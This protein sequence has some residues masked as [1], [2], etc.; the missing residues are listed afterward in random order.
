MSSAPAQ[1][2]AEPRTSVDAVPALELAGITKRY[3]AATVVDNLSLRVD[4]GEFLALVGPS[5]CGKT[6]SLR[7]VAGLVVPD[8]GR[9]LIEGRDVTYA[10]SH[11]RDAIMVFQS[12]ALF[13][14]K[15]VAE[16]VA[17]GLR[18]RKV[19]KEERRRRVAE[20]LALV[21]LPDVGGR[22]PRQ[23]SGGQQQRIALARALVL[24]PTLLLLDEPLSNLDAGLRDQ[25]RIELRRLHQELG[26]TTVL[27]THDQDEALSIASRVAVMNGGRIE[28][29]ARPR[30]LYERPA[31][32]FVAGFVG[33]TNLFAAHVR[34]TGPALRLETPW[35]LQLAA[36]AHDGLSAGDEVRAMIRPEALTLAPADAPVADGVGAARGVLLDVT[37]S[38][39][40]SLYLVRLD[41]GDQLLKVTAPNVEG[42][43]ALPLTPGAPVVASWHP[44]AVRVLAA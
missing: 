41:G 26:T 22:F 25:M 28:Q 31:T 4:Q 32:A 14:H 42:G 39:A 10:P 40:W 27:V 33:R 6:T 7:M 15:S 2:P 11:K 43:D 5:G 44:S 20:A 16:N 9:I 18:R 38:G 8:A 21:G 13:P 34:E 35:G 17:Y 37:Y 3:R 12:Y 19:G 29:L 1:A 36:A 23:L 30:E 24:R